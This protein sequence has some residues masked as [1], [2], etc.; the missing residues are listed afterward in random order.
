[1]NNL[2]TGLWLV[3]T[4]QALL[5]LGAWLINP[6]EYTAQRV[7]GAIMA[8]EFV[9]TATILYIYS[10]GRGD[11]DQEWVVGGLAFAVLIGL[12]TYFAV[13]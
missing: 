11:Y 4:L 13:R 5:A 9:L 12:L 3:L 1:M 6:L 10:A 2:K 8:V 7:F